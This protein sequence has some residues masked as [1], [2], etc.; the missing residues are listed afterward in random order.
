MWFS[1]FVSVL[2]DLWQ[3]CFGRSSPIETVAAQS[4]GPSYSREQVTPAV[5]NKVR[6]SP[7]VMY[8]AD[9]PDTVQ[10]RNR[11][12]AYDSHI[13]STGP[14]TEYEW[15]LYI[16]Q[17]KHLAVPLLALRLTPLGRWHTTLKGQ[18]GVSIGINPYTDAL[19]EWGQGEMQRIGL[20]CEVSPDETIVV[21][22]LW[23]NETGLYESRTLTRSQWLE[24]RPVFTT[25]E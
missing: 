16:L 20:I 11:L 18:P 8:D 21:G 25:F 13:I 22:E 9:N 2:H 23:R 4:I 10:I 7:G 24:L 19:M 14:L 5:V 15:L 17:N 1:S 3:F 12:S 6:L